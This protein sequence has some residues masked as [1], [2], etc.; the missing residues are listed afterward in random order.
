MDALTG[1]VLTGDFSRKRP[2]AA[3]VPATEH[4]LLLAN[5]HL[6]TLDKVGAKTRNTPGGALLTISTLDGKVVSSCSIPPEVQTPEE[7]AIMQAAH[8]TQQADFWSYG[9]TFT[10]GSDCIILRSVNRLYCIGK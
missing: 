1:K 7:R 5:Q 6:Y 2:G 10:F 8:R 3:T 9:Y 4:L